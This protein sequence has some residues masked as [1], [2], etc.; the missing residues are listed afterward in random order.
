MGLGMPDIAGELEAWYGVGNT[1]PVH[2]AIACLNFFQHTQR[3]GVAEWTDFLILRQLQD[4][5]VSRFTYA[6]SAIIAEQPF[7]DEFPTDAKN[8]EPPLALA[9]Y[10]ERMTGYSETILTIGQPRVKPTGIFEREWRE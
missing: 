10:C 3:V 7:P 6:D 4:G 9:N 1:V 2:R 5:C 8:L